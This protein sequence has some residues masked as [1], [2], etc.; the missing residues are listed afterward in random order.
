[1]SE[2]ACT[3]SFDGDQGGTYFV[4]CDSV[5][6]LSDKDLSSS[7]SETIYLYRD[8]TSEHFKISC[9]SY[10]LPSYEDF[11]HIVHVIS[12]V[13]NVRFNA[14][15]NIY[16]NLEYVYLFVAFIVSVYCLFKMLRGFVR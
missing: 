6:F 2:A 10:S 1:M 15:S 14:A 7:Y 16:R 13:S 4:P 5:K 8:L 12:N 11:N 3:V 9:S